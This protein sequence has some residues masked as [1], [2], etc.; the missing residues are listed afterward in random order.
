MSLAYDRTLVISDVPEHHG[1]EVQAC[2]LGQTGMN[3]KYEDVENLACVIN[4]L[5]ADP[6]KCQRFAK[7]GSARVRELMGPER[8]L[9]DFLAAIR[10]V[11][12]MRCSRYP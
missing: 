3:Y 10:Y 9:D 8:M 5:L 6:E 7:A 11:H 4:D 2:I 12:N 1:P